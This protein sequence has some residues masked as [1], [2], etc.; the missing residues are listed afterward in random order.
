[1]LV[2]IDVSHDGHNSSIVG[3]CA[4]YN[5]DL[6]KYYSSIIKQKKNQEI[7]DKQLTEAF[8]KAIQCYEEH[9]A[10]LP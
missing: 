2:G 7:V 1:M 10:K 9:N 3:F 6:S 4:T 8:G 5:R